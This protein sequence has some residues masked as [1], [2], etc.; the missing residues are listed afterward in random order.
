MKKIIAFAGSNSSRSINHQLIEA[1][2]KDIR[3]IEVEVLKLNEF[4]AQVYGIDVENDEGFP[5]SMLKLKDKLAEADGYII[6]TPE[7]NGSIPAV[8]KN[9]IDWLSRLGRKVFND[10]PLVLFSASPGPRGG[11]SALSHLL[12][13]LP[14]QGAQVI[15]GHGIG[16]FHD[17]V[18]QSEIKD[19][20][21]KSQIDELIDQLLAA[22]K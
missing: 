10:K 17:V 14:Y 16:S 21:Q 4:P 1:V 11:A 19:H 7:H 8:L 13:L 5:D 3:G 9:T 20:T 22:V 15:G 12:S 2:T 6:S 18:Q